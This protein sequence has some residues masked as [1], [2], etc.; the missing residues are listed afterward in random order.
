[1]LNA[2]IKGGFRYGVECKAGEI[3]EVATITYDKPFSKVPMVLITPVSE[4]VNADYGKMIM[5]VD[6]STENGFSVKVANS[7]E[8]L[9]VWPSFNWIAIRR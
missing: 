4:T 1:M 9:S 5:F 6:D 7:G 3:T 2:D 8:T